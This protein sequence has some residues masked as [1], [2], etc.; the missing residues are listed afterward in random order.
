MTRCW[1][2]SRLS[3]PPSLCLALFSSP[4]PSPSPSLLPLTNSPDGLDLPP[5]RRSPASGDSSG[6]R[7]AR[8]TG[9]L[10]GPASPGESARP[11]EAWPGAQTSRVRVRLRL[12]PPQPHSHTTS[13][14][15]GAHCRTHSIQ[16]L[17]WAD[18]AGGPGSRWR[19]GG[20][21]P[22]STLTWS[23]CP[24]PIPAKRALAGWPRGERKGWHTHPLAAWTRGRVSLA[25]HAPNLQ[26]S[27]CAH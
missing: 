6:W 22:N 20:G 10:G 23:P 14:C 25:V 3:S 12:Q 1:P 18:G 13:K 19:R 8:C 16:R 17:A 5:H 24:G 26:P 4:L 2:C 15:C 9:Q 27:C 7:T 21:P 11:D